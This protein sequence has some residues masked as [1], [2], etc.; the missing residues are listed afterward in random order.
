MSEV[1]I[2]GVGLHPFGRFEGVT[3][4]DM[5][6]VAVRARAR[7][8]RTRRPRRRGRLLRNRL[9]RGGLGAPGARCARGDR[10][11]HL[12]RRGG[13][14]V[15]RR[16]AAAG[17][18]VDRVGTAR[19]RPRLRDREDAEGGHPVVLLCSVAGGGGLEPGARVLR[20]ARGETARRDGPD[21]RRPRRGGR[22]EPRATESTTPTRC[23]RR[24][25]PPRR[26]SPRGWSARR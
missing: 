10:H 13:V 22:E 26:S 2:A 4:T 3:A 18:R 20:A 11:S 15:R 6:V 12:R 24:R 5:G 1:R 25:S 9:R 17:R 14:R 19:P 7:G 8:G 23:S 16:R 21:R